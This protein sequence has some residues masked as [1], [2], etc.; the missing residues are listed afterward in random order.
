MDPAEAEAAARR[1]RQTLD[2]FE[3]GV[4]MMRAR[5]RREHPDATEAQIA[6]L[7][8]DWLQTRPGAE[9]GDGPGRP[10]PDPG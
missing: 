6:R 9:H 1:L 2:L 5:L 3:T 8:G 4:S 7:L 10:R